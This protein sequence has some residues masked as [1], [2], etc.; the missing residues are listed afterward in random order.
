MSVL[1]CLTASAGCATTEEPTS[2]EPASLSSTDKLLRASMTLRGVRPSIAELEQVAQDPAALSGIVDGYLSSP[3]FGK[4]IRDMHNEAFLLRSDYFYFPAGFPSVGSLADVDPYA[5]NTSVQ[6]SAL[7]LVEHVVMNDRPFSEIVTADYQLANPVTAAVWDTSYDDGGE[8][9]QRVAFR[10]GRPTAGVLS[11]PWVFTR[12]SSTFSNAN[13]GRANAVSKALLCY[14][15]LSRDIAIDSSVDLADPNAVQTAVVDNQACAS[16]HQALDPLAGFFGDYFP[17][18]VPA[19]LT[20]Y[21][22]SF[23]VDD[24]GSE[25]IGFYFEDIFRYAGIDLRDPGYF[26]QAGSDITDLGKMMAADPRFSRCTVERFYSYFHQIDAHDVPTRALSEL[27]ELF[28]DENLD[29][30]ALAKAI[31]LRD[32]FSLSHSDDP[33]TA[34]AIN[35]IK[36]VRPDQLATMFLDLTGFRWETN[37]PDLGRVELTTDSFL[38]FEVLGGGVD[39]VYVTRPSHTFTATSQLTLEAL[40]VQAAAFVVDRDFAQAQSDRRL[41]SLVEPSTNDEA[42]LRQQLAMLHK[43]LFSELVT[44]DAPEV[45]ETLALFEA[46]RAESP[47]D[48]ARAWQITLTAMLQDHRIAMY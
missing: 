43:R 2:V 17:L 34:E 9:W 27:Q 10:D 12:Y 37:I 1:V 38:G 35:G 7:R 20:S 29:A 36:K 46:A 5:L 45:D 19:D 18:F 33:T 42:V 11:D 8:E 16:C 48:P 47:S 32:D 24:E 15:F 22:V 39:A 14:D 21:P 26:G 4:V 28:I 44:P 25:T 31:V 41:L 40:A 30:K 6:E 3:T 13:R 23:A